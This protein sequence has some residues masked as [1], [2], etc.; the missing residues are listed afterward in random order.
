[1]ACR[2]LLSGESGCRV[3]GPAGLNRRGIKCL[4]LHTPHFSA[5]RR[6]LSPDPEGFD[7]GDDN[8]YRYVANS[9][10]NLVDPSGL[11]FRS[12]IRGIGSDFR[13]GIDRLGS[14]VRQGAST[15]VDAGVQ[16]GMGVANAAR[17]LASPVLFQTAGQRRCLHRRDDEGYLASVVPSL[18]GEKV[19]STPSETP[20]PAAIAIDCSTIANIARSTLA[21]PVAPGAPR[22]GICLDYELPIGGTRPHNVAARRAPNR[23][24]KIALDHIVGDEDPR[25]LR[26]HVHLVAVVQ[27]QLFEALAGEFGEDFLTVGG[28]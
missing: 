7:A 2:H 6:W 20:N 23:K 13:S 3:S 9:P 11:D 12:R 26:I 25:V 27:L 21:E 4:T 18:V 1:M 24:S 5:D 14:A 28:S 15:L 22:L 19:S 8:L 10:V 17:L 16:A